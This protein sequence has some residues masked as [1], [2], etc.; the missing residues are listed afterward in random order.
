MKNFECYREV[1][2]KTIF[3]TPAKNSEEANRLFDDAITNGKAAVE[4]EV[5]HEYVLE[6]E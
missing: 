6:A 5:V 3:R 1:V 2:V 4:T